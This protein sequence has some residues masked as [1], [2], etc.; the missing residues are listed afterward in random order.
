MNNVSMSRLSLIVMIGLLAIGVTAAIML[1]FDDR[2]GIELLRRH[3]GRLTSFA[4]SQPIAAGAM[5]MATYAAAVAASVPGLAVLTVAGGFLFGSVLGTAYTVIA[6]T[7]A[8]AGVF[9]LARSAFGETLRR[10]AGPA[11]RRFAEDFKDSAMSYI[12]VLHL[13]PIFPYVVVITIPAA[14]GVPLHIFMFSAFFGILPATILL[15]HVGSGLG[16]VLRQEGSIEISSF[17]TPQILWSLVG[18]ALLALL[19]VFYRALRRRK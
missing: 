2:V 1:G 17:M 13:I 10:R 9:L 11:I 12:F 14:C 3:Q 16:V 6:T 4:T 5:F 18:L 8:G 7:I 19:P 15:A